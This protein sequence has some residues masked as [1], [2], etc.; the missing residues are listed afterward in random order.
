MSVV[1]TLARKEITVALRDGRIRFLSI[2]L[3]LLVLLALGTGI[4]HQQ[5]QRQQQTQANQGQR[6][7]WVNQGDVNPH[8]AAHHGQHV[9]KP[10]SPLALL[11][12]GLSDFTG[13]SVF[14]EAH[15]QH[16]ARYKA[17]EDSTSTYRFGLL[18]ANVLFQLLV[19]LLIIL[20]TYNSFSGE[21]ESGTLRQLMSLG[22]QPHQLWL[23]K[24][25]G[26]LGV[27][28]ILLVPPL[29]LGGGALLWAEGPQAIALNLSRL[30]AWSGSYLL[31]WSLFLGLG[32][33]VSARARTPRMALVI[34][35]SLWFANG[36][37]APRLG[38]ALAAARYQVPT[39]M[40]FQQAIADA[41]AEL[42][43]WSERSE[44]VEKRLL[45]QYQVQQVSQLPVNPA[46]VILSE[47]EADD[48]RIYAQHHQQLAA[49]Y[50]QQ[51]Q[52]FQQLGLLFPLLAT[53]SLSSALAGT[54]LAHYHHFLLAAEGYRQQFVQ[55]LN[56][57][58]T[59][60]TQAEDAFAYTA[61]REL[62]ETVTPFTYQTPG[63]AWVTAYTGS[64]WAALLGWN[65]LILVFT[66][67]GLRAL[68]QL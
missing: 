13:S 35:L 36:I 6:E 31:F 29:A 24:L 12:P 22:L 49:I 30:G 2:A 10:L 1:T 44:Q 57:D 19:P 37:L 3:W 64:A 45:K 18:S 55:R 62:W 46:G 27:L 43:S 53:Q 66:P 17:A 68:R 33:L 39:P 60:T 67:W 41:Q 58:V 21:R 32:L 56:N 48:T 5:E 52:V 8:S 16:N 15:K 47:S 51:N 38:S 42:P 50:H 61:N 4:Q 54:D 28:G 65:L 59:A 7:L 63:L 23:G 34:L 11:D 26:Y 25:L 20:L 14:L 9:F 40:A